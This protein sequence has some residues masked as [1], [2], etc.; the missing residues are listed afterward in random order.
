LQ[1]TL[2]SACGQLHDEY[3]VIVVGHSLPDGFVLPPS[4]EFIQVGFDP[5]LIA[6]EDTSARRLWLMRTDKGRK[7]L[8]GLARA[9]LEPDAHVMFLDA[10][11]LVSNRL[12]G[13]V[14]ENP[15]SNGWYFEYGYRMDIESKGHPR[16]YWRRNFYHE[17]GSS[18]I[19][20]ADRAPFPEQLDDRADFSDYFVRRY[21]VHAYIKEN[22]E[23]LGYPLSPLPFYGA[24]YIFHGWNIFATSCRRKDSVLRLVMRNLIKRRPLTRAVR[25]EFGIGAL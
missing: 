22:F 16:L 5:P 7:M 23:G 3:R 10:D 14:A 9:R 20:R 6:P 24:I 15:H 18:Y 25:E 4:C 8:H 2:R 13:L 12:A 19:L 1:Q 17:C 21:E 11:D